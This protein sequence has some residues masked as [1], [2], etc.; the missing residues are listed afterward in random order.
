[1]KRCPQC[2]F[3]YL[4][5]DTVCDLDGSTLVAASDS[6]VNLVPRS[7]YPRM[8]AAR[9]VAAVAAITAGLA[10][11]AVYYLSRT[12]QVR[13]PVAQP[14]ESRAVP[15]PSPAVTP[16]P[17]ISPSP[18]PESKTKTPEVGQKPA[19]VSSATVSRNPVSTSGREARGSAIIWLHNGARIEADEV[20]RTRQG[21]W[22]RRQGMV[23]LIKANQVRSIQRK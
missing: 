19:V 9:L 17:T 13:A 1:M 8:R 2:Q 14:T 22:Y 11:F 12:R 21:V 15:T 10:V 20:C 16:E 4:D 6:D 3:I 18:S 23:T 5:T 7:R